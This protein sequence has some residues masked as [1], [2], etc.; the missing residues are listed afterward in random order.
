MASNLRD[1]IV[2]AP[3]GTSL[4]IQGPEGVP[5]QALIDYATQQWE[6]SQA[7]Q[8]SSPLV[9]PEKEKELSSNAFARHIGAPVARGWNRLE[10]AGA[11]MANQFGLM[12]DK[13]TAESIAEDVSDMSKIYMAPGVKEGMKEIQETKGFLGSLGAVL[14][15]PQA[16]ADTVIT[17][18]VNS[19]PA[20]GGMLAG[21]KVGALAG[22]AV[23]VVGTVVGGITGAAT[24]AG[25]GSLAVEYSNS[26][27]EAFNKEGVDTSNPE[28]VL[29]FM[30]DPAKMAKARDYALKRGVPIAVFDAIS[31]GVASRLFSPVAKAVAGQKAVA[32]AN[33]AAIKAGQDTQ[34]VLA[35]KVALSTKAKDK[36]LAK[37]MSKATTRALPISSRVAGAGAE[38]G[39]QMLLGGSGEAA[40]QLVSEG[41]IKS[42][43]EVWLEAIAEGPIGIVE[44]TI[45]ARGPR[46]APDLSQLALPETAKPLPRESFDQPIET[47]DPISFV[48]EQAANFVDDTPFSM[49]DGEPVVEEDFYDVVP[50]KGKT[51]QGEDFTGWRIENAAGTP[52]TPVI[53]NEET[54]YAAKESLLNAL[55]DVLS[56]QEAAEQGTRIMEAVGGEVAALELQ[57]TNPDVLETARVADTPTTIE[58]SELNSSQQKKINNWRSNN[59]DLVPPLEDGIVSVEELAMAGIQERTINGKLDEVP[60]NATATP[61]VIKQIASSKNIDHSDEAF[62]RFANRVAGSKKT[63]AGSWESMGERQLF[64]VRKKLSEMPHVPL[65]EGENKL[66]IPLTKYSPF[67]GAQ[68][69]SVVSFARRQ[70]TRDTTYRVE[71]NGK[72]VPRGGK[73][74]SRQ[75]AQNFAKSLPSRKGL[76]IKAVKMKQPLREGEIQKSDLVTALGGKTNKTDSILN[77]AVERGDLIRSRGGPR[78]RFR[79]AEYE[80]REAQPL[81]PGLQERLESRLRGMDRPKRVSLALTEAMERGV[82]GD[83]FNKT[84]TLALNKIPENSTQEEALQI[85]GE[86]LD[87]EVI[88]A[89]FDL[90]VFTEAEIQTLLRFVE[91]TKIPNTK[92]TYYDQAFKNYSGLP[93]YQMR[94]DK[95]EMIPDVAKIMEEGVAE[96][97]KDFAADR[98]KPQAQVRNL[99]IRIIQFFRGISTLS[100]DDARY[101]VSKFGPAKRGERGA[102]ISDPTGRISDMPRDTGGR[103]FAIDRAPEIE[104]ELTTEDKKRI[105]TLKKS[106]EGLAPVLRNLSASEQASLTPATA[107]NMVRIFKMLPTAAETA[108]VALSGESKKGWYVNSANALN[109]IFGPQDAPRFAALLAAMSPQTSVESNLDNALR[110]WTAW[111]VAGRPT[112]PDEIT[113]IMGENVQ[114]EQA[115]KSILGA[116]LNNSITALT[117]ENPNTVILSGPKVNS[118]ML[119]LRGFMNEV[120][121]DAWMS[122][123]S[124]I[125]PALLAKNQ[126]TS[127]PGK[128]AGYMAMNAVVRNAAKILSKQTGQ[129]WTPAEV[130]ETV[131]SWAKALYEMSASAGEARNNLQVLQEGSLTNNSINSVPDFEML[132]LMEPYRSILSQGGYEGQLFNL[133]QLVQGREVPDLIPEAS[134]Y[135]NVKTNLRSHLNRAAKRLDK[136]FEKRRAESMR[137]EILINLSSSTDT[138]RGLEVLTEQANAG[139]QSAILLLQEIAADSLKYLTSNIPSAEVDFSSSY[140]LYGGQLEPSLGVT[141]SFQERDRARAL[142]SIAKFSTNFNQEQAHVRGV[143]QPRTMIPH[144]YEDGSYNTA[145]LRWNLKN[146]LTKKQVEKVIKDSGLFGLTVTD[147]YV[148]AYFVG[149]TTNANEISDFGAAT[150]RARQ[151]LGRDVQ[152]V[153]RTIQRLWAYGTGDGATNGYA[154]IQGEFRAPTGDQASASALRVATRL[155]NR[156]FKP[157]QQELAITPEKRALQTRIAEAFDSMDMNALDDPVVMEAYQELAEELLSQYDAMPIKVEVWDKKGEPYGGKKMSEKMR[158]DILFNNHLYIFK[159]DEGFG[160]SDVSYEGHPLLED[161]GRTDANE[162]PLVFN[163]LLRAVHDYYAHT[164]SP[165]TFGPRG[166]E[167]AWRNHML[168]TNS[169]WARWA[170]TSETRGQNSWV[171]F[172]EGVKGVPLSERGFGDQKV[173]LLPVEFAET[174]D[175]EVDASLVE[176]PERDADRRYSVEDRMISFIDRKT[177]RARKGEATRAANNF[178]NQFSGFTNINEDS[179]SPIAMYNGGV[180]TV[181][182]DDQQ[183]PVVMTQG[184]NQWNEDAQKYVGWG[185]RHVR[186][187]IDDITTNTGYENVDAFITGVLNLY[188]A[189]RLN[190]TLKEAGFTQFETSSY[191]DDIRGPKTV[192]RYYDKNWPYPGTIVLQKMDFRAVERIVPEL[193]GKSFASVVTAYALPVLKNKLELRP[194]AILSNNVSVEAKQAAAEANPNEKI[195]NKETRR[196]SVEDRE[197]LPEQARKDHEAMFGPKTRPH[198]SFGQHIIDAFVYQEQKSKPSKFRYHAID[199]W[200][201]VRA[202]EKGLKKAKAAIYDTIHADSSASAMLSMLGRAAGLTEA[203]ITVGGIMYSRGQF[204]A[205]SDRI[206]AEAAPELKEIK[207]RELEDFKRRNGYAPDEEVKGMLEIF[208]P[209]MSRTDIGA[210]AAWETYAAAIRA[211]R[212]IGE[213]REFLL[214]PD[215]IQR[216][217]D[218][219]MLPQFLDEDGKSIVITAYEDYQKLN[220][221]L[222]NMMKD[223]Q[224]ISEEAA[225]LWL[226]N[227]DYM[228]FYREL[229]VDDTREGGLDGNV[230]YSADIKD[231]DGVRAALNDPNNRV[232]ENLYNVPAPKELKGGKTTYFVMAG[233][234]RDIE[235]YDTI[236]KA[237]KRK[238]QL[239]ELNKDNE[240]VDINDIRVSSGT[241]RIQPNAIENILK[242]ANGAITASMRNIGL[243]RAMRDQVEFGMAHKMEKG[244]ESKKVVWSQIGI[245]VN[246]ETVWYDTQDRL[247]LDAVQSVNKAGGDHPLIFSLMTMPANVL[248]ELITKTPDFMAANLMR[249]TISAWITS[250]IN[251]IP[252]VGTVA[253]MVAGVA[254]KGGV[255]QLHAAGIGGGYDFKNDPSDMYKAMQRYMRR[256]V[257]G[258]GKTKDYM[259]KGWIPTFRSPLNPVLKLWQFADDVTT[260]SDMATRIAVYNR[261][262]KETGNEAQ[263]TIEALEVINFSRK[264]ANTA[265]QW[266]TAMVPFLNARL[267]GLDVLWR[268]STD[269]GVTGFDAQQRKKRFMFRML[270]LIALTTAYTLAHSDDP[271]EDPHYANA[272]P[273]KRDMY[274]IIPPNWFGLG[275]AGIAIPKI[276]IAFEVGLLTKTIPE[277]IINLIRGQDDFNDLLK[278][279]GRSAISTLNFNVIPQFFKPAFEAAINRDFFRG[280]SITPYWSQ[281]DSPEITGPGT[282]ETAKSLSKILADTGLKMDAEKIEHMIRGY[283]GTMGMYALQLTDSIARSVKG[284]P[285]AP[286]MEINEYPFLQRFMQSKWG[287]GDKKAFYELRTALDILVNDINKL[288]AAGDWD[289]A[290]EKRTKGRSLFL[291]KER[292]NYIDKT[293]KE[294]R[295]QEKQI[296]QDTVLS[297]DEKRTHIRNIREFQ[298]E[299]LLGIKELSRDSMR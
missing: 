139:D 228:P 257:K 233:R 120:T 249:D 18:L 231:Q 234:V 172:R 128:S 52:V 182:I 183:Y 230:A 93:E 148:E 33:K 75:Q 246:G 40:A 113:K 48:E 59:S 63:K 166:E 96:A 114:G 242:N 191:T 171:N 143:K 282:G 67:T 39:S 291:N 198:K 115:E 280:K 275:N 220:K 104:Y 213:K 80:T 45:G 288:E 296:R 100:R 26:L 250:G 274:Y 41:E 290:E 237:T 212:L 106:V 252:G 55:P 21:M 264:G 272:T 53:E 181:R 298:S 58:M 149:D 86:T 135:D 89:L 133:E 90:K 225:Q 248:R 57:R 289:A 164:M 204:H 169:P 23:P 154:E 150:E 227:N 261:I 195:D 9:L 92:I 94:D 292:I 262:I 8:T 15:N 184:H 108:A 216:A 156:V 210:V 161:S 84:I 6:T 13:D 287:G 3:D 44:A 42:P 283:T 221:S 50:F 37:S 170:L 64:A 14:S 147:Q 180:T 95:G 203:Y 29:A 277:R 254:G 160:S 117:S 157:T 188:H 4:V 269:F 256:G 265:V 243:M 121:N 145:V 88:H 70:G 76:K 81:L 140:G 179:W 146:P 276:P 255:S 110:V 103:R 244:T 267:Q 259:T 51:S 5:D 72:V 30:Q 162:T 35:S 136:V 223:A 158:K 201:P 68:Y 176:L 167:A 193:K 196:F 207:A 185:E 124:N 235:V 186:G 177:E 123:F 178:Q 232:F 60:D 32:S 122:T 163:D 260:A 214:T 49:V 61:K 22:S 66:S 83:Y 209:V 118:F 268:G 174:G 34:A 241:Q 28:A 56:K 16:I 238:D 78:G 47:E 236:E 217:K 97:F 190:G 153:E 109:S 245:R 107:R 91:Q 19:I 226:D 2:E 132:L 25:T 194:M 284:M 24:G 293:L 111:T 79:L 142:S 218:T 189:N 99:F 197:N 101:F 297:A 130:Q 253:G 65:K 208:T 27:I 219:A 119:N 87:H 69:R 295:T 38:I 137:A 144:Q 240:N 215:Q 98:L 134:A 11:V 266:V 281:N 74:Y 46:V 192:I 175:I 271:E 126:S 62:Q 224:I 77:A 7:S 211:E 127:L 206:V 129:T 54:A 31:G 20:L 36:I 138:I 222:I 239:R 273:E 247:L 251:I 12:S 1:Y 159:T 294:L 202:V 299:L 165:V 286:A 73:F 131:W 85:L 141:M 112:S 258:A 155:A 102:F 125:D 116:W 270:S 278:S 285:D 17:S 187:H 43:G 263:A 173:D 105:N 82:K 205:M 151:S 168:M 199:R 279:L 152:N 71:K 229:Y 10:M 200:E